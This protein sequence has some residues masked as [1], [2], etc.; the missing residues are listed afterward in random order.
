MLKW[1]F[2]AFLRSTVVMVMMVVV[3]TVAL[4]GRSW[5]GVYFDSIT[6]DVVLMS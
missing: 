6:C 4:D 3:V 1:D 5:R 2:A